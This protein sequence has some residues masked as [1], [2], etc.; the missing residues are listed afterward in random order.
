MPSNPDTR[1]RTSTQD[2]LA[3]PPAFEA[4]RPFFDP[5]TQWG[6]NAQEVLAYR[7]LKD[8]FPELSPQEVFLTVVTARRLFRAGNDT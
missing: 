7:L 8:H 3:F 1:L 5:S 2:P 4:L 6:R